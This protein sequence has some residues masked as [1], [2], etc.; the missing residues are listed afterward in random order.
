[1]GD[2]KS[3]GFRAPYCLP[4]EWVNPMSSCLVC[5]FGHLGGHFQIQKVGLDGPWLD[6]VGHV[7][8]MSLKHFFMLKFELVET[9]KET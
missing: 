7:V 6:P 5:S 9:Y 1:M 3:Q 8:I 2:W 4:L